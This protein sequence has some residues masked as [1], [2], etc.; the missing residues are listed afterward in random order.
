MP[1]WPV[2]KTQKTKQN[3]PRQDLLS[4]LSKVVVAQLWSYKNTVLEYSA[5]SV[6]KPD[7]RGWIVLWQFW[8]TI[9]Y[10]QVWQIGED[11]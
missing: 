6:K 5:D 7:I 4:L 9:Q 1:L 2:K 8:D 3:F 11:T 10:F